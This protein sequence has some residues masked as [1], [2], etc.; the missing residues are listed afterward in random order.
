MAS[1]LKKA[2]IPQSE[3]GLK[4]VMEELLLTR[5]SV[6]NVEFIEMNLSVKFLRILS[7]D[8]WSHFHCLSP[9]S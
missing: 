6:A 9:K 4:L 1:Q 5:L 8:D 3:E 2:M 7:A